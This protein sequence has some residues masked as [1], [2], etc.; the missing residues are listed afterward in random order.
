[1]QAVYA[2]LLVFPLDFNGFLVMSQKCNI[3]H[4]LFGKHLY[5]KFCN[6]NKGFVSINIARSLNI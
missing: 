6:R 1:M 3:N 4:W 2:H 5:S